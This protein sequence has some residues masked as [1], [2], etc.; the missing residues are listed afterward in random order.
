[1]LIGNQIPQ[2]TSD[3]WGSFRLA[4]CHLNPISKLISLSCASHIFE[5]N[6]FQRVHAILQFSDGSNHG[7]GNSTLNN[8]DHGIGILYAC[9]EHHVNWALKNLITRDS[10][11]K[12]KS[13]RLKLTKKISNYVHAENFSVSIKYLCTRNNKLKKILRNFKLIN[14]DVF[15][16]TRVSSLIQKE[17]H[18]MWK[19]IS[20]SQATWE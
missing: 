18:T 17:T 11:W 10:R 7:A 13:Q 2:Q 8:D 19:R 15:L 12:E 16:S 1:M 4:C 9:S 14:C 6:K 3:A 5:F 20:L